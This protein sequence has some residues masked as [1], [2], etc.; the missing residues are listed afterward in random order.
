MN[1]IKHNDVQS[2]PSPAD[3]VEGSDLHESPG[4][5]WVSDHWQVVTVNEEAERIC[6]RAAGPD[7]YLSDLL[8][9]TLDRTLDYQ[10]EIWGVRPQEPEPHSGLNIFVGENS[11][12]R[13]EAILI[14]KDGVRVPVWLTISPAR[15]EDDSAGF[16]LWVRDISQR[17]QAEQQLKQVR[18]E[19][20]AALRESELKSQF[21]ATMSHEIRTPMNGVLGMLSLLLET[22][23]NE[24]Q[25]DYATTAHRSAEALLRVLND[26]LDIS[27]LEAGRC[28]LE[29]IELNLREAV[30]DVLMIHQE[31]ARSRGIALEVDVDFLV[32]Q[33]VM[34]DP[35]R[36]RQVLM[37]LVSNAVKFTHHGSVVLRVF[38][39]GAVER[40]TVVFEVEDTGIGI[41]EDKLQ[42]LFRPFSQADASTT[43]QFGGTGLGLTISKRLVELMGGVIEVESTE[44]TGSV[45]RVS[46]PL[47]SASQVEAAELPNSAGAH[48]ASLGTFSFVR[49]SLPARTENSHGESHWASDLPPVLVVDDNAVNRKFAAKVLEKLGFDCE[50]AEDGLDA[51]K[52]CRKREF[53]AVLMDCMMPEMDG[54]QATEAIRA[55]EQDLGWRVPIIA[56]TANAMAGDR[57]RALAVGMD[58][59]LTK[60]MKPSALKTILARW[61]GARFEES[62]IAPPPQ[63]V[64]ASSPTTRARDGQAPR[65]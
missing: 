8:E 36:I 2:L 62:L 40:R 41:A 38:L 13:D 15:F 55:A 64:D 1:E 58:D 9:L 23:L 18:V 22:S 12:V 19:A 10:L 63:N 6:G 59:Y 57:E 20:E 30:R 43:R 54:Y 39:G 51:L 35:T 31:S 52:K 46:L 33:L 47:V 16:L 37:N 32:P 49:A 3:A 45:F 21:L 65:D 5:I 60:P 44:G 24:E 25:S 42:R 29:S 28:E 53:S 11:T 26:V 48:S 14:R 27:K 17:L 4:L 34:T 50:M 61:C 56:V 7:D